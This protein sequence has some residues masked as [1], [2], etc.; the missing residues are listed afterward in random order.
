MGEII[1]E[2]TE[3]PDLLP[4]LHRTPGM[5]VS[6]IINKIM[7]YERN[8]PEQMM[9]E[10]GNAFEYAIKAR[11]REHEPGRFQTPS[12][13]ERN[14][15]YGHPDLFDYL[16][17]V[18]NEIKVTWK[19]VNHDVETFTNYWMQIKA[20]CHMMDSNVGRLHVCFIRGDYST[21]QM[22][23]YRCWKQTF[24]SWE[25]E[26][27]WGMLMVY[28][29]QMEAEGFFE[30][31]KDA[32]PLMPSTDIDTDLDIQCRRLQRTAEGVAESHRLL[33]FHVSQTLVDDIVMKL[34]AA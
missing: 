10:L 26:D 20:Y 23:A 4:M 7:K 21:G 18:D 3:F 8:K 15:V 5:H 16:D 32:Q 17:W 2:S 11:W 13:L 6:D 12:E 27:N 28:A 14:G 33:K 24:E 29:Q 19:S 1:L 9:F 22:V 25:L 31:I 30:N 34:K